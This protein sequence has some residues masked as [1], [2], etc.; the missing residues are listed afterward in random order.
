MK[1]KCFLFYFQY[2]HLTGLTVGYISSI[3]KAISY[4]L[5]TTRKNIFCWLLKNIRFYHSL[6]ILYLNLGP[7]FFFPPF[8]T[9]STI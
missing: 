7:I 2:H 4:S 8:T 3:F 9:K 5:K 1:Q 6:L